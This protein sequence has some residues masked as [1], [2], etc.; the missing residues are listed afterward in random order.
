MKINFLNAF[1]F[2]IDDVPANLEQLIQKDFES[3]TS[4]TSDE[5][6]YQDKLSYID[7][8][9]NCFHRTADAS[10]GVKRVIRDRIDYEIDE[11]REIP[12][13]D[14]FYNI[15]FMEECYLAGKESH[16]LNSHFDQNDHH[17]YDKLMMAE[18]RAIRAVVSYEEELC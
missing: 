13:K 7:L 2:D 6:L 10:E 14:D 17:I 11:Y 1:E 15:A 9:V 4:G 8:I 12:S 5:F 3:Y 18:Y 16:S